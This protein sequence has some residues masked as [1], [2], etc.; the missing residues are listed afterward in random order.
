M[1]TSGGVSV[2]EPEDERRSVIEQTARYPSGPL[3]R[4][5]LD[6][7]STVGA[8]WYPVSVGMA[9]AGWNAPGAACQS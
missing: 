6:T 1:I 9:S 7:L 5:P 2:G 4:L 3:S 8:V